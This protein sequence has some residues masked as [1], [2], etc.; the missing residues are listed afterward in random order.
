MLSDGLSANWLPRQ[1]LEWEV[2]DTLSNRMWSN[3]VETG[4]L[5]VTSQALAA[6]P[7]SGAM[8]GQPA[9]TR[10]DARPYTE[11]QARQYFPDATV[12]TERP[13]MPAKNLFQNPWSA[14]Y[15]VESGDVTRELRSVVKENNR[16]LTVES[17]A[18]IAGRTFEHQWI[19]AAATKSIVDRKI[20]ASV[21]LRPAQDDYRQTYLKGLEKEESLP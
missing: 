2:R 18:R 8:M 12:P 9:L 15:D 19:P 3:L 14:G 21:L 6:H 13:V 20:E 16:N 5:Q 4:P 17:S 7:T 10:T 11:S 1:R